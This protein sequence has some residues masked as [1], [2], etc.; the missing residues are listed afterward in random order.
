MLID[1]GADTSVVDKHGFVTEIIEGVSVSDQG[2]SYS[3][4]TLKVLPI[5]D[6]LYTY[7]HQDSGEVILL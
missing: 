6:A 1:F 5:V 3:H 4:R 7:N 2:F